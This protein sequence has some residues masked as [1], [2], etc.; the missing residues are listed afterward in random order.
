MPLACTLIKRVSKQHSME[1]RAQRVVHELFNVLQSLLLGL[2]PRLDV[3][4]KR[5]VDIP[6]R[7]SPLRVVRRKRW[8]SKPLSEHLVAKSETLGVVHCRE[9]L[10]LRLQSDHKRVSISFYGRVRDG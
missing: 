9:D 3:G 4:A 2:I 7:Y 10:A 5:V 1:K 6:N 8:A